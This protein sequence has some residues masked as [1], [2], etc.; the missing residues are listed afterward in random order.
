MTRRW[1]AAMCCA[2]LLSRV[3]VAVVSAAQDDPIAGT[4]T[5]ALVPDSGRQFDVTLQLKFDGKSA[6]SGTVA[7]LPGPADVKTGSFNP[8]TGALK[9]GLGQVGD[10]KVLFTLAGTVVKGTAQGRD[11]DSSGEGTF[12]ITRKG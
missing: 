5:G 9:L 12:K 10:P 3:P 6:V 4:W 11:I 1:F 2:L 7:G 8:K